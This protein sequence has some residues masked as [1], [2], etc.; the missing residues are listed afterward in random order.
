MRTNISFSWAGKTDAEDGI[1]TFTVGTAK[2]SIPL[3]DF[4]VAYDLNNLL[5]KAYKGGKD[6]GVWMT[7]SFVNNALD[8]AADSY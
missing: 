6:D 4:K 8:N 2:A 3:P 1:A 7:S 5:L